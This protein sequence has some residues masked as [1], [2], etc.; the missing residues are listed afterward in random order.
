[1]LLVPAH[2]HKQLPTP[3]IFDMLITLGSVAVPV[4]NGQ[5]GND[6]LATTA[7]SDGPTHVEVLLVCGLGVCSSCLRSEASS[8]LSWQSPWVLWLC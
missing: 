1:M 4:V 7:W 6:S 3:H 8:W 5:L 2:E